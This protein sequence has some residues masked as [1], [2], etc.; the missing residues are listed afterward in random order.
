MSNS[1]RIAGSESDE[2]V[3]PRDI[4]TSLPEVESAMA[5]T[6]VP[7]GT[8][9]VFQFFYKDETN[10]KYYC[11]LCKDKPIQKARKSRSTSNFRRHLE[12]HHPDQYTA[13]TKAENQTK[14]K[15]H[16]NS[17]RVPAGHKRK[18]APGT[19]NKAEQAYADRKLTDWI[20]NHSQSFSVVDQ[21]DFRQFCSALR[22]EYTVPSR[23]TIKTRVLQ[24]WQEEKNKT[25]MRLTSE[26]ATRRVGLTT[27]MWTSVAKRGYM[28]VTAHYITQDWEMRH[29]II[30]FVRVLY[31]HTGERLA[32]HLVSAVKAMD[33]SLLS[34]MWA[35]TGDNATSNTT[36]VSAINSILPEAIGEARA[37]WTSEDTMEPAQ[38]EIPTVFLLPCLAHTL[39][40]AVK[41]GL[42]DCKNLDAAIG[43]FRDLMKKVNDSPKLLEALTA[44]S[45]SLDV[46]VKLPSLDVETR[47]N[48][49][50]EMVEGIIKMQ[51]P[52]EELQRRIRD[53][54]QGY[55]GFTIGPRDNLAKAIPAE[56]W[57]CLAD[58]C[59]FLRPFKDVTVL[60]SG[61]EYPTLG[62]AIPMF[63]ICS[64]HAKGAVVANTGF[65]STETTRFAESVAMKL[66]EYKDKVANKLTR[67]ATAL[68][69]RMKSFLAGL[70]ISQY[71][72]ECDLLSEYET[73]YES[74]Y[75]QMNGQV[76]VQS[77]RSAAPAISNI[78]QLLQP[79]EQT[80]DQAVTTGETFANELKRWFAL[81]SMSPQQSSR[82]ICMWFKLNKDRYPRI[83]L[84]A[85]DYMGVTSTSVPSEVAFSRAGATI[86]KR[87]ARLDDDAVTALCELQS[88]LAFNRP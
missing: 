53:R 30:A 88:F 43:T 49:T 79:P 10:Q 40:L 29:C 66:D 2:E 75:N 14:L 65:R 25:R 87:R 27:D 11:K 44:I 73:F 83:E 12:N 68:D 39:Q 20:V 76:P 46:K 22:E 59:T 72:I 1:P 81:E 33:P 63:Y 85:R 26:L 13:T 36:M 35:I 9:D 86:S 70:G 15:H 52:L 7:T 16:F 60:M 61:T 80:Q 51:R 19:F 78:W 64:K 67:I 56:S 50:W 37:Y 45:S 31:P 42:A 21:E 74:R 24:R 17:S 6:T 84:M 47:W 38:D 4:E 48:S 8:S 41:Q 32:E 28:V 54:H 18:G 71:V 62:M 23:N 57:S 69:P 5:S 55:T 58:F 34:S 3:Q 77:G 82:D